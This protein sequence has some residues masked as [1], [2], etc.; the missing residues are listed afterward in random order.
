MTTPELVPVSS[1]ISVNTESASYTTGNIIVVSGTVKNLADYEQDI[2]LLIISPAGNI[3]HIDQITTDSSGNYSTQIK[4]GGKLMSANGE[5]EV[6]AHYGPHKITTT[7]DFTRNWG[8][9]EFD[10][11]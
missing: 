2:S 1:N 6:H 7:F 8:L 4:S 9:I 11:F 5:Y 3:V 10:K